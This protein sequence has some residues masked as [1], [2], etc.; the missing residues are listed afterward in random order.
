MRV[1]IS[2]QEADESTVDDVSTQDLMKR[3]R[4]ALPRYEQ[5]RPR[6]IGVFQVLS[7]RPGVGH[8]FVSVQQDGTRPWPDISMASVS[9]NRHGIVSTVSPLWRDQTA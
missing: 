8:D 4:A 5:E 9:L 7:D 6:L 1:N 2:Q 3:V